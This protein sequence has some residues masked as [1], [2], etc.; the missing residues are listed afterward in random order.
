MSKQP[1]PRNSLECFAGVVMAISEAYGVRNIPEIYQYVDMLFDA[2]RKYRA[3][4]EYGITVLSGDEHAERK[5]MF[6]IF[7]QKFRDS[8]GIEYP[9]QFSPADAKIAVQI[10]SKIKAL[11]VT[12]DDY[13]NWIFDEY[14]SDND[15]LR[16]TQFKTL[17]SDFFIN[18]FA[19]HVH[20]TGLDKLRAEEQKR[21]AEVNEVAT[22][23]RAIR[24][25]YGE[26]NP[27]IVPKLKQA[28]EM[29]KNGHVSAGKVLVGLDRLKA[30][31]EASTGANKQEFSYSSLEC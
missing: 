30:T 22:R 13:L 27:D 31:L 16:I 26:S 14:S 24:R 1:V 11:G 12:V 20:D 5:R 7:A 4:E 17:V 8:Y 2:I 3:E 15:K 10:S 9:A 28:V 25:E 6:A 18:T 19:I 21:N 23:I 29:L